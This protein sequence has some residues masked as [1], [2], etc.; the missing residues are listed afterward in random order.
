[1][2]SIHKFEAAGL[3]KAPYRFVGMSQKI[4]KAPGIT[5]PG[6]CCDYCSTA[7]A[8]CFHLVSSDGKEFV[9]G[10]ECIKK[11]G[12][13]G[14]MQ[15]V[16]QAESKKR[17]ARDAAK[18]VEIKAK[19]EI[20]VTNNLNALANKPHP[21]AQG[22]TL[23]DYA[24]FMLTNAGQAGTMKLYRMLIKELDLL[25]DSAATKILLQDRYG[26]TKV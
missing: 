23:L 21:S 12:D 16:K 22:L 14:L 13:A 20:I 7:I 10:S 17:H 8:N 25:Q 24:Q 15:A 18:Y 1:M 3:G 26:K 5:K 2:D 19:L 4:F 9:V 11:V 6:G